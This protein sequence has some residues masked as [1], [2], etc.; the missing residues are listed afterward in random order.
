MMDIWQRARENIERSDQETAW[1]LGFDSC[2]QSGG[3]FSLG[4]EGREDCVACGRFCPSCAEAVVLPTVTLA[5]VMLRS[6]L[7]K[8][9]RLKRSLVSPNNPTHA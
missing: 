9:A 8:Y 4:K 6:S 3:W 1:S 5:V 7:A 2:Q